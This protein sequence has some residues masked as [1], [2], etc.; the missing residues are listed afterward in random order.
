MVFVLHAYEGV[1]IMQILSELTKDLLKTDII[2][3]SVGDT[4]K[5]YQRITE[6]AK[7]RLQVFQGVVIGKKGGGIG[8][9]FTVRKISYGEGVEKVF[10]YHSPAIAKVE[11]VTYGKVRRAKLY[12]LREAKSRMNKIKRKKMTKKIRKEA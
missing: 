4:I 10:P 12:Y 8:E 1:T 7:A 9:S 6:G 3:F 2:P 11:V 5:V